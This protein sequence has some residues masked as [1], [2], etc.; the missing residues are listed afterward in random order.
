AS[1]QVDLFDLEVERPYEPGLFWRPESAE[2]RAWNEEAKAK[3][4][5]KANP[6]AQQ[7]PMFAWL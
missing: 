2:I 7:P 4:W 6:S 5:I 3:A 1:K